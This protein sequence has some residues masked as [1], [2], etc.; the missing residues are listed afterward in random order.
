MAEV[1]GRKQRANNKSS[2][3]YFENDWF[4]TVIE[5]KYDLDE[6]WTYVEVSAEKLCDKIRARKK[7]AKA[8]EKNN[9][10]E[11][12][13]NIFEEGK[14]AYMRLARLYCVAEPKT[15]ADQNK[16]GEALVKLAEE[17]ADGRISDV[18]VPLLL[19]IILLPPPF[20]KIAKLWVA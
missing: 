17:M 12:L 1:V 8:N 20:F 10:N 5:N 4:K 3:I 18:L 7:V 2:F 13:P 19:V 14:V 11:S 6:Y 16:L 9:T 15:K